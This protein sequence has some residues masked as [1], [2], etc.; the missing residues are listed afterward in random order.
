MFILFA[1]LTANYVFSFDSKIICITPFENSTENEEFEQ[2]RTIVGDIF[3]SELIGCK[4]IIVVERERLND[5]IKEQKLALTGLVNDNKMVRIGKILG[6]NIILTG[7]FA[8][9]ESNIKINVHLFEVETT[10]LIKSE[11]ITGKSS[12]I[13]DL[14]KI[15]SEKL[16][17]DLNIEKGINKR[18]ETD[19]RFD[20]NIRFIKGLGFYYGCEY[21]RAILEFMKL[22]RRD[23]S[24]TDA[25]FW[26][27][28]SYYAG[29]EYN[30]AKTDYE[31]IL[32]ITPDYKNNE[33]IRSR[34]KILTNEEK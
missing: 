4:D 12:E 6:A 29:K 22:L 16:I 31:N 25:L 21:D 23:P 15:L 8:L 18:E 32:R 2:L 33:K 9:S 27:A 30:H 14:I 19:E 17:K 1:V 7:G 3:A 5:V 24:N 34:I 28:E 11:E 13:L 20:L 26:K 10:R